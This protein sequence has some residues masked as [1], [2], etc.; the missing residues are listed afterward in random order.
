MRTVSGVSTEL[1]R[2]SVHCSASKLHRGRACKVGGDDV[3]GVTTITHLWYSVLPVCCTSAAGVAR[4]LLHVANTQRGMVVTHMIKDS[5]SMVYD[6]LITLQRFSRRTESS[7]SG[8]KAMHMH[9]ALPLCDILN[10]K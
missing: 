3:Y 2:T 9:D 8:D 5:V 6:S 1:S 10:R 4:A 7:K